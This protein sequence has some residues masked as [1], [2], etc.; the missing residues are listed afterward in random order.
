M[1]LQKRIMAK[2][3]LSYG[4]EKFAG[5]RPEIA[6]RYFTDETSRDIFGANMAHPALE[7]LKEYDEKHGGELYKTLYFFLRHERSLIDSA[8]ALNIHRNSLIYW[9]EKI[10]QMTDLD[11][12]DAD[13]REY[14]LFSYR[15]TGRP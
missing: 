1:F 6:M 14:L 12:D 9:I 4:T 3:A 10:R 8:R 7:K 5:I 2:V 15:I 11:L 13:I